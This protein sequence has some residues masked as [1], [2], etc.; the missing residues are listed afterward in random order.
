MN[1]LVF[2]KPS[3]CNRPI[4]WFCYKWRF[5]KILNEYII[6]QT[7]FKRFINF[8]SCHGSLLEDC[9]QYIHNYFPQ[10]LSVC[11]GKPRRVISMIYYVYVWLRCLHRGFMSFSLTS[12][13][14]VGRQSEFIGA[15][16][17]FIDCSSFNL[18]YPTNFM[19]YSCNYIVLKI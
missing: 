9:V 15:G 2:R 1:N 3:S 18:Y 12:I 5:S 8:A 4:Q 13:F 17:G 19:L 14:Y 10:S 11:L 6:E 16:V 7:Y